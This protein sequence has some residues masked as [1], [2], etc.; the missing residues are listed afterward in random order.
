MSKYNLL[1]FIMFTTANWAQEKYMMSEGFYNLPSFEVDSGIYLLENKT[2]FYY[3]SFGNVDLRVFG[4]YTISNENELNLQV[5]ED[6]TKEF[7]FYGLK[8]EALATNIVLDYEQPYSQNAER[9]YVIVD[10]YLEN[11]PE[12]TEE[13]QTVSLTVPVPKSNTFEIGYQNSEDYNHPDSKKTNHLQL[14]DGINVI[15]IYHNYYAEMTNQ[16]SQISFIIENGGLKDTSSDKPTTIK[17]Q[18]LDDLTKK[19][20]I[21]FIKTEKSKKTIVREGETYQKM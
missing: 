2:F 4:D 10:G 12:F 16:V 19:D 18:E 20:I 15:K 13:H 17:K 9:I 5:D 21:E 11:F 1:F 7:T 3:A 6:L 8:N 14:I